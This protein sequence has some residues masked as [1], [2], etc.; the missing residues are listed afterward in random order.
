[1]YPY[2]NSINQTSLL[3]LVVLTV[4]LFRLKL[5]AWDFRYLFTEK[6]IKSFETGVPN[7][8]SFVCLLLSF[9]LHETSAN[10]WYL[11]L[12]ISAVSS[13][14][15]E[16]KLFCNFCLQAP[17]VCWLFL[18]VYF[19]F[20]QLRVCILLLLFLSQWKTKYRTRR[21]G[22]E[23]EQNK[24]INQFINAFKLRRNEANVKSNLYEICMRM[25]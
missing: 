17:S 9:D 11:G 24:I 3:A 25:K 6:R 2:T 10:F 16:G 21:V 14:N 12:T 4:L 13:L 15:G 22:F 23:S 5:L 20:C 18:F 19:A 1:M 7:C 8:S